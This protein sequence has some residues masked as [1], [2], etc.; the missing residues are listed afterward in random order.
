MNV[1][2]EPRKQSRYLRCFGK[3]S[4]SMKQKRKAD[5]PP[6]CIKLAGEVLDPYRATESS[7]TMQRDAVQKESLF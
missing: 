4:D 2:R 7:L 1:G 6:G 5:G 3:H